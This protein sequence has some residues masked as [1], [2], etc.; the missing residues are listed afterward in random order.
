MATLKDLNWI[1]RKRNLKLG[2]AKATILMNQ[3][4]A[5]CLFL[6]KMKIMDYSLLVGIH[7][8]SRGNKDNIRERSI[9]MYEPTTPTEGNGAPAF[10]QSSI[11]TST[12]GDFT[13][14]PRE[15]YLLNL[16]L[17]VFRR[18]M[19]IYYSEDGGFRSTHR[20]GTPGDELYF[21]GVIDILTPYSV[22]KRIEHVFKSIQHDKV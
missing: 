5:D 22:A 10:K 19:C 16:L 15:F 14:I 1:Q 9:M 18:R 8:I 6:A 20:D 21:L 3:L 4:K 2:P 11:S 13:G 12:A 7:Y 17:I